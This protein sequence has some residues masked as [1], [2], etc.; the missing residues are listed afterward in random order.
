MTPNEYQ[1]WTRETA[2]YP[3]KEKGNATA[4]TYCTLGVVGEAGEIA[5]MWKKV[6]RRGYITASESEGIRAAIIDEL[7]D[8]MWYVARL[9]DEMHVPLE[10]VLTRNIEK[11][12][13]RKREGNVANLH[14]AG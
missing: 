5:N 2:V 11:L 7:G 10:E 4:V 14:H 6:L 9:A 8:V 3:S 13:A 1:R 12:E